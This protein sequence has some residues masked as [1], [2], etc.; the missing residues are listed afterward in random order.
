MMTKALHGL[1]ILAALG[2]AISLFVHLAAWAGIAPPKAAW[3]LHI[4]IFV[5]WL[6]TVLVSQRL[7]R[8]FKQREFWTAALRGAPP[9]ASTALKLLM[10]YAIANFVLFMFQ[11]S[12]SG[13]KLNEAIQARGFSGHWLIFYGAAA[14]TLYSAAQLRE[15]GERLR[16]CLNGHTVS[17]TAQYCEQ[18]G[19]PVNAQ[20]QGQGGR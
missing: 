3:A 9:W 14:A 11:T 2:F 19:A 8:D 16:T 4:G 7:T 6:P 17:A 1:A 10:G 15:R 13:S 20:H 5:V 18:C 12:E